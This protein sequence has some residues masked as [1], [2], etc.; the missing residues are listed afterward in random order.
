VDRAYGMVTRALA[1]DDSATNLLV[2]QH[3][4][5]NALFKA[6]EDAPDRRTKTRLFENLARALVAH[7]AIERE[8]FY[9]ACEKTLG[10][11]KLLGEALVEH[12]V[13]EFCL[14]EADRARNDAAFDF[15]VQVLSEMVLH[16][17]KEEERD[18]FPQVERAFRLKQLEELGKRM[19]T[20]FVAAEKEDF[21]AAMVTNLR[22]VLA[23]TLKPKKR[24]QTSAATTRRRP[25]KNSRRRKAA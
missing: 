13:I 23:G 4:E 1:D 9:P 8:I 20:R 10:M 14:Y 6:I 19:Q 5:V 3:D 21:R 15:K 2:R 25:T 22:Q 16:H 11:T 24:S 18:F 7:D 12:G 17:V